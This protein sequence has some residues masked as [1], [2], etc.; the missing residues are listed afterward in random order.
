VTFAGGAENQGFSM[1]GAASVVVPHDP[2]LMM[3]A[4]VTVEAWVNP[5]ELGGRIIDK[6][7]AFGGDGYL[8]D[9]VGGRLR[10]WV[11]GDDVSSLDF[12]PANVFTHV[13][14]TYDGT[15]LM[16]Y[17]NG[18]LNQ[19]KPTWVTAVTPN[20]QP[21]HFGQDS[22]GG[23]M[24]KGVI[25]EPRVFNRALSIEEVGQLYWQTQNCH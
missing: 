17:F 24:F 14:G 11:S 20:S 4:A 21:M 18:G 15:F 7:T 5:A 25:D 10:M 16:V 13:V 3:S 19:G 2:S 9:I 6:A 8:M 23:S 22:A 1:D 12:L